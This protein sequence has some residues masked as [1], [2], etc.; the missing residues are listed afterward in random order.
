[1]AAYV[2]GRINWGCRMD[3]DGHRN[4]GITWL[5]ET[6]DPLDGPAIVFFAAGLPSIGSYWAFGNDTDPWAYCW[7]DWTVDCVLKG[8]P[9]TLWEVGQTFSTKPF[10]R[11]QDQRPE[12]PLA[13]PPR[14]SG[15]FV[16]YSKQATEDRHGKPIRSASHEL[17]RGPMVEFDENR[18]NVNIEA[19]FPYLPLGFIAP[20]MNT[21][22]DAP[23]WGLPKRCVKLSGCRWTRQV[24]GQCAFYFT[25]G[26]EFDVDANTFDRKIASEGNKVLSG[27]SLNDPQSDRLDPLAITAPL[28]AP[29]HENPCFFEQFKGRNGENLRAFHDQY[30]RPVEDIADVHKITVEKYKESNMLLLGVP[31]VIT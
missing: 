26:L 18:H 31:P 23:L 21:L 28:L 27:W 22:N 5:V 30:G 20:M 14:L 29:N 6:T 4:Y 17:I 19:N 3:N 13:E 11:C 24:Y 9:G 12:N 10:K 2:L 15:S 7:P 1:M 8:E 25:V 16:K